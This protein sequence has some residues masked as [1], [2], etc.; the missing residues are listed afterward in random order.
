MDSAF[1]NSYIIKIQE[2]TIDYKS[3]NCCSGAPT[4]AI[5]VQKVLSVKFCF[6]LFTT[7]NQQKPF[8]IIHYHL[9]FTLKF[10]TYTHS[11]VEIFTLLG[12]FFFNSSSNNNNNNSEYK[13]NLIKHE[14]S[15]AA[16]GNIIVI[17]SS[18]IVI[19]HRILASLIHHHHLDTQILNKHGEIAFLS[20]SL[21]LSLSTIVVNKHSKSNLTQNYTWLVANIIAAKQTTHTQT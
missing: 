13:L 19:T 16:A 10:A 8:I 5:K 20:L 17:E 15:R 11:I 3:S 14:Q 21:S 9:F 2:I 4:P 12:C 18:R 6:L 1:S 7:L